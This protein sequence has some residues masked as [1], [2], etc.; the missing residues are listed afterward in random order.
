[1][2]EGLNSKRSLAEALSA[3]GSQTQVEA[4]LIS[5]YETLKR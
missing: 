4:F 2:N 5:Y 3:F 1:M